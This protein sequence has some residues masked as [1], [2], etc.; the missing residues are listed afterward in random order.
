MIFPVNDF[1]SPRY[2]DGDASYRE[3]GG[4]KGIQQLVDRFYFYMDTLEEAKTIRAM[5]NDELSVSRDKLTRFLCG[6]LGGPRLYHAKY[7]EIS[8]PMAHMHLKIGKNDRDAWML[9]MRKALD[10]QSYADDFKR[11]LLKQLSV[12]AERIRNSE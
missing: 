10:D 5:H 11:Y 12:P 8:I 4:H 3:A 2:G 1:T 7:G 9:C 6:W